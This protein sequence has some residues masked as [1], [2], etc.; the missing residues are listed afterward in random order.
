MTNFEYLDRIAK[1]TPLLSAEEER[2]LALKVRAGDK[3]ARERMI[4]ANI[5]LVLWVLQK[6]KR[7]GTDIEDYVSSGVVGLIQAIDNFDPEMGYRFATYAQTVVRRS[8]REAAECNATIRVPQNAREAATK[9]RR[10]EMVATA[11][12]GMKPSDEVVAK[13]IGFTPSKC[14]WAKAALTV[15]ES[16]AANSMSQLADMAESREPCPVEVAACAEEMDR[17]KSAVDKLPRR[18]ADIVSRRYGLDGNKPMTHKEIGECDGRFRQAVHQ[19]EQA[20]IK[21]LRSQLV[22]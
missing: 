21:R 9:W 13:M 20:A 4:C 12:C 14:A 3:V 7:S 16:T 6:Y 10:G 17:I 1:A 15:S 5:K 11:T 8:V 2:E 19:D 22:T 18:L